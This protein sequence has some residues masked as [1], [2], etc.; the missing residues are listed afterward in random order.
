VIDRIIG[1]IN[2]IKFLY[3]IY[4]IWEENPYLRFAQITCFGQDDP[5]YW[6]DERYIME[7]ENIYG[8]MEKYEEG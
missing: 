5:Y 4:K 8:P 3:R 7:V 6:S 2:K 1:K